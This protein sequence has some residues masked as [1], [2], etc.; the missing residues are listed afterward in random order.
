MFFLMP[1]IA[2]I[3]IY[4][5]YLKRADSSATFESADTDLYAINSL[6]TWSWELLSSYNHSSK[7]W[8]KHMPPNF[9]IKVILF[10]N[11][12]VHTPDRSCSHGWRILIWGLLFVTVYV[13]LWA[14]ASKL[15]WEHHCFTGAWI[16]P[17]RPI[18]KCLSDFGKSNSII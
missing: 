7:F 4:W 11:Y 10:Q 6:M 8:C 5:R 3:V 18:I 14:H 12:H 16:H 1:T 2:F 15:L 13:S 17:S 9:G